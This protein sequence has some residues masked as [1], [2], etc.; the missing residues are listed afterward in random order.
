MALV[1][2][3]AL[4]LLTQMGMVDSAAVPP[5]PDP[6]IVAFFNSTRAP[7]GASMCVT[8]DRASTANSAIVNQYQCTAGARNQNWE[9]V[10]TSSGFYRLVAQH[11]G[12]YMHIPK[13]LR[14]NSVNVVQYTCQP[15]TP[16]NEEW[17]L[18]P[19]AGGG[20][21]I[22]ARHSLKCLNVPRSNPAN[23]VPLIQYTCDRNAANNIWY[24]LDRT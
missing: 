7:S 23:N 16:D 3:S 1:L 10:P 21:L 20:Y 2:V 5:P 12:K 14:G 6:T 18:E 19:V 24:L 8:V 15:G 17:R 4:G 13:A 11:S 22:Q 9:L